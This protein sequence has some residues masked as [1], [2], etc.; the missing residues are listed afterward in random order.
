MMLL[1]VIKGTPFLSSVLATVCRME[2]ATLRLFI[3]N[4]ACRIYRLMVS[5]KVELE[6][7]APYG[8]IWR[9]NTLSQSESNLPFFR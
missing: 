7:I 4:P 9:I 2:C 1:I 6:A 8:W 5:D 3:V